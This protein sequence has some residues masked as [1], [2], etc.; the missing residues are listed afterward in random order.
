MYPSRFNPHLKAKRRG[1][2]NGLEGGILPPAWHHRASVKG[3]VLG[4]NEEAVAAE[5]A[6]DG[7]GSGS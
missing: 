4:D 3:D 1:S 2:L 5:F 6:F 7:A